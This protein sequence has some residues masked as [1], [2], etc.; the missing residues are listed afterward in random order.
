VSPDWGRGKLFPEVISFIATH[1]PL[2]AKIDDG[3]MARMVSDSF[4]SE[5]VRCGDS[6][7]EKYGTS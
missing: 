4:H 3:E 7:F 2:D 1:H 5:A 6:W